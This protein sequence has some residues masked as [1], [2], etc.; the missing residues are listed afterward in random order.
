METLFKD[1]RYGIRSLLKR[2]GFAAIAVATL[3]LA[4][5]ANTAIF[6]LVNAVLLRPL[7]LPEPDRLVT[8]WHSAPAKNLVEVNLNDALYAYYRDRSL[9]FEKRSAYEDTEFAITGAGYSEVLVGARVTFNYF[10]TLGRQPLLGRT[11]SPQE[12]TPGKN[13]VVILS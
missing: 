6:S 4:I 5:G 13:D 3:A 1:I 10:D 9:S 7:P 2:P 11:F 8:F 12:D